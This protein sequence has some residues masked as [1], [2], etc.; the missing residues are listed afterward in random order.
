MG[1]GQKE[2]EGK[3]NYGMVLRWEAGTIFNWIRGGGSE[4]KIKFYHVT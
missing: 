4:S 2:A 3:E 1:R